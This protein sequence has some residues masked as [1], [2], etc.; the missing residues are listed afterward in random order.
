VKT[1]HQK[2]AVIIGGGLAGLAA[3][4]ALGEQGWSVDLHESRTRLG[5]RASSFQDKT[6]NEVID[7]CQ[8]VTMGCCTNFQH[9]CKTTGTDHFFR[10]EPYLYFIGPD[11]KVNQFGSSLLPAPFH[12]SSSFRRLSY[13]SLREKI[14]IARALKKLMGWK[15]DQTERLS[16]S[17]WLKQQ[18]QSEHVIEHF[19]KVVLTS[20]LSESMDRISLPY[21]RKVFRDG[22]VANKKGWCMSVPVVPLN[23]LYGDVLNDW[24]KD[25]QVN[26]QMN[27][28]IQHLE[29]EG[30]RVVY[31]ITSKGEKLEADEFIIAIPQTRI[32]SLFNEENI[33]LLQIPKAEKLESA[34][35]SS[36]HLW[37]DQP[38]MELPHAVITGRMIQWIFNRDML[39]SNKKDRTNSKTFYYQI[40]ISA[41][42]ELLKKPHKEIIEIAINE[43]TEIWPEMKQVKVIHSR[44]VSEH[45]AV[46]SVTP[47]SEKYR[48]KQKT[49]IENLNFAG[50][51]TVTGWP[52][53]ME[54]AVRS[55]YLA[56]ENIL[57]HLNHH[58]ARYVP[59]VKP[60]L[61]ASWLSQIVFGL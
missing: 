7:N 10:D 30:N 41:S 23:Q 9:F 56:V 52:S 43:L 11:N 60:D 46:I 44:M 58:E 48:L 42:N 39:Q 54:G 55:G 19:W 20:A 8:H 35:I 34:S 16:F 27:S 17:D 37:L 28:A 5:G 31:A 61:P 32:R 26:I 29:I 36:I 24:F 13:F 3:A 45:H 15:D 59:V 22:F 2:K 18:K 33:N 6:T 51:W 38:I 53:T 49:A 4:S 14:Q 12:L 40:V 1:T 50:D 47:E 57:N 21:A 25:H